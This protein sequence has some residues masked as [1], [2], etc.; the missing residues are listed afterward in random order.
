MHAG[1]HNSQSNEKKSDN[2][3][4]YG[5]DDKVVV[6]TKSNFKDVIFDQK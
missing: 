2:P 3:G 1:K 6:L 4:F 5:V